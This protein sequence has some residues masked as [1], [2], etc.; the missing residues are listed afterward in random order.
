VAAFI[1]AI[2]DWGEL[3]N[4]LIIGMQGNPRQNFHYVYG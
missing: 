2:D 4:A 3:D 1:D